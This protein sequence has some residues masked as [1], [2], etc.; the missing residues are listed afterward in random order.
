MRKILISVGITIFL[1]ALFGIIVYS[2]R[3]NQV[4][5]FQGKG[6]AQNP[7]LI[8]SSD[9]LRKLSEVVAKGN[10]CVQTY[11]L[12]TTDI[13]LGYVEWI[14]IGSL[15]EGKAFYGIYD[16][17]N[18]V[19]TGIYTTS[20]NNNGLFGLLGGK[21]INLGVEDSFIAGHC[22]GAIASHSIGTNA[23]V[24]NCHSK[25]TLSGVRMG[26][27]VDNFTGNS[28]R[29]CWSDCT[30]EG[31]G[32][33]AGIVSYSASLVEDCWTTANSLVADTFLGN[34]KNTISDEDVGSKLLNIGFLGNN[35]GSDFEV[36]VGLAKTENGGLSLLCG[37]VYFILL[38]V[39]FW[40]AWQ[41]CD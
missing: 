8:S 13:D 23:E 28:I 36:I 38:A 19:I 26:G 30:F 11:F 17:N 33:Y 1:I 37:G 18:H 35:Y 21:V 7:Y 6:T 3:S 2:N 39:M 14:P 15:E 5:P 29:E 12:Q 31:D 32:V 16:G 40:G 41:L 10:G 24:I 22:V 20:F 25:V 4:L 27:I 9:D 34:I